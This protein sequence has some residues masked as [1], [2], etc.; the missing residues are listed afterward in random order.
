[1]AIVGSIIIDVD[2]DDE[3]QAYAAALESEAIRLF[4]EIAIS[5]AR[6]LCESVPRVKLMSHVGP[7]EETFTL[8]V[9]TQGKEAADG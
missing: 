7:I 9:D 6:A 8:L 5:T 3:S 1:M 4:D 2:V